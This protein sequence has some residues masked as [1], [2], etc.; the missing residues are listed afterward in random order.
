MGGGAF[1]ECSGSFFGGEN[2]E[3]KKNG[4]ILNK[5]LKNLFFKGLLTLLTPFQLVL[6]RIFDIESEFAVKFAGF[7]RPGTEN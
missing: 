5:T 3:N 7:W 2:L 6:G 4:A 1:G